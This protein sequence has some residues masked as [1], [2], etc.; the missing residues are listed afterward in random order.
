MTPTPGCL[1]GGGL[2]QVQVDHLHV[3]ATLKNQ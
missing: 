1:K 2:V 3:N